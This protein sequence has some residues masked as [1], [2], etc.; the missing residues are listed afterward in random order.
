VRAGYQ[1][2]LAWVSRR[3][4]IGP[5]DEVLEL[6]SGTGNLARL[7]PPCR[8]LLCIDISDEMTAIAREK[9]AGRDEVTF[10]KAD[11]LEALSAA[12]GPV[13][14]IVSTYTLHHLTEA[15][16]LGMLESV[17]ARLTDGG[18]A[19]F[20]D[21]MLESAAQLQPTVERYRRE[22]ELNV[23]DSLEDEF[24][25]YVDT[26]LAKLKSLGLSAES[27]RFSDLSWAIMAVKPKRG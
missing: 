14:A 8:R 21:L 13:D 27:K 16:K 23:V 25:W 15:E 19:V 2:V 18:R 24:Y 4:E 1:E 26:A 3:A 5:R 12:H 17:S 7:L 22:G 6:G 11:V 20:G 10:V 9:L